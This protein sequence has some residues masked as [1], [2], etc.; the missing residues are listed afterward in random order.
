[1][2]DK[3]KPDQSNEL[4]F[5]KQIRFKGALK[6][7]PQLVEQS[8]VQ[9][10]ELNEKLEN[11]KEENKMREVKIDDVRDAMQI[12]CFTKTLNLSNLSEIKPELK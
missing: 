1:M 8:R 5:K 4:Q 12:R 10:E 3:E 9:L 11:F 7:T 2:T 6:I